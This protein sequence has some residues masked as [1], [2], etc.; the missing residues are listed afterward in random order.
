[1]TA[2]VTLEP[3]AFHGRTPPCTEA[4]I[5]AG[6]SRVV[7]PI[8]DPHQQVSGA[9]FERLRQAGVEVETG[10]MLEEAKRL[11]PGFLKRMKT[12]RPW[13]RVKSAVSLDGRTALSNGE[14]KWITGEAARQD[15]QRWRARSSAILTGTG[16]VLAD[17]PE[18]TAR[19][20]GPVRQPIRVLVDT[21]WRVP[22]E[23]KII[24]DGASL[25]VAGVG[26]PP[27]ELLELGVQCLTLTASAGGVDLDALMDELGH[28]E[29]NEIQV[30]AGSRLC[31]A[32]LEKGL[33]DEVLLYVAPVLLGDGGPGPFAF[34]PLESMHKRSHFKVLETVQIGNDT[35]YRLQPKNFG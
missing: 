14:S 15:V 25:L 10:L 11:N 17:D 3:C 33:V 5:E 12:G 35:R 26:D 13:V 9:G 18:M 4:L 28:R 34:G 24:G 19:V 29:L 27:E 1:M 8:E 32:L 22:L 20:D 2:Y 23:S 16:T 30:E 21:G 6:I 7:A 31:G